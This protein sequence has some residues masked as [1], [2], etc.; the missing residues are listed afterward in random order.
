M[1]KFIHLAIFIFTIN[2]FSYL[3]ASNK[4]FARADVE[5]IIEPSKTQIVIESK[6][7]QIIDSIETIK[8]SLSACQMRIKN[9][10]NK[11]NAYYN[12][13]LLRDS[14]IGKIEDKINK[15]NTIF[16]TG[17]IY[18]SIFLFILMFLKSKGNYNIRK[19]EKY[20]VANC[21]KTRNLTSSNTSPPEHNQQLITTE[22]KCDFKKPN[23]AGANWFVVKHSEVGKSHL[24]HRLPCQ[25]NHYLEKINNS[26]GIAVVCDGAGSAKNSHIGSEFVSRKIS[27]Y[28]KKRIEKS[29]HLNDNSLP[30]K[31]E[32]HNFAKN[33]FKKVYDDLVKFA[34]SNGYKPETLAC[35]VIV[36]VYS[37]NGILISHIGDGRAGY[38]NQNYEWKALLTPW[39]GEEANQTI[40]ITSSI[41]NDRIDSYVRSNIINEPPLAFTLM[42]DG[43]ESHSF[44]CSVLDSNTNLWTDPNL[45]FPDFFNPLVGTLVEFYESKQNEQLIHEKW[46]SFIKNGTSGIENESDDK[47]LILGIR[48]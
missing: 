5:K 6:Q 32:W 38:M 1:K 39:K 9:I 37:P 11:V 23:I 36:V 41:W 13:N 22:T 14:Q 31:D 35:T 8:D 17:F 48:I 26:W 45:P 19:V 7:E 40:F 30:T 15:L 34:S 27:E 20:D 16:N 2:I 33:E 47:T 21:E 3:Y 18:L 46:K 44:K 42:S 29:P 43:M 4:C 10:E 24:Q 12:Q 25:D 28:L